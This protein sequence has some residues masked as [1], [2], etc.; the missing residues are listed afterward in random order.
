[1]CTT[2]NVQTAAKRGDREKGIYQ[3]VRPTGILPGWGSGGY[4]PQLTSHTDSY[5]RAAISCGDANVKLPSVGHAGA[6][7]VKQLVPLKNNFPP[8]DSLH[9]LP[10]KLIDM[11]HLPMKIFSGCAS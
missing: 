5:I 3:P 8:S 2:E 1:M 11:F 4:N 6:G 9:S 7:I 10:G